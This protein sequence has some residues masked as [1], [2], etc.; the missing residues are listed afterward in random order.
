MV[1][2]SDPA[3]VPRD[4]PF[5]YHRHHT[6]VAAQSK[7]VDALAIARRST[8]ADLAW[9][10]GIT[11]L[12]ATIVALA[13]D[14]FVNSE[15]PRYRGKGMRLRAIG[16]AGSLLAVPVAWRVRGRKEPYPRGLDALVALPLLA[17]AAGNAVGI[18]QRAHVDDAIHF[19]NGAVL[20]AVVGS[21]A[22]PRVRTPWEAAGVATAVGIAASA[23]WEIAEWIGLKMGAK[24]MNLTYDDT[25]EDLIE[26]S[27]GALLGGLVTLLRHPA[28]LRPHS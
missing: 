14:A 11:A 2:D 15:S 26:G 19:A 18:Y 5:A 6:G 4:A 16:Y 9:V 22:V 7:P 20:S 23:G 27:V 28:R 13:I 10:A 17:D 12:K 21:L 3:P 24:G 25:M 8:A 1:A